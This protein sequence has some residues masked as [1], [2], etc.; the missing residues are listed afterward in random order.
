MGSMG[1]CRASKRGETKMITLYSEFMFIDT[2]R[3]RTG[4]GDYYT[5]FLLQIF[6]QPITKTERLYTIVGYKL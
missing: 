4:R 3:R 2:L 6:R 5:D 1:E